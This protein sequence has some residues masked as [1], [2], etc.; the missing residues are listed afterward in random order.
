MLFRSRRALDAG[1]GEEVTDRVGAPLRQRLIGAVVADIIR[2]ARDFEP[3]VGGQLFDQVGGALQQRLCVFR[4]GRFGG[5]EIDDRPVQDIDQ[6]LR[7]EI[8]SQRAQRRGDFRVGI[9]HG[10]GDL[11]G[12]TADREPGAK[13]A[14][15]GGGNFRPQTY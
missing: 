15:Q 14:P 11:V 5:V 13:D 8:R 6:F 1:A 12:E 9:R 3:D 7:R 4:H 10:A 2:M